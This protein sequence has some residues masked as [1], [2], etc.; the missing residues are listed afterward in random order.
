[1][2]IKLIAASLLLAQLLL[3]LGQP[4]SE[5]GL[6]LK[7]SPRALS[8]AA[9]AADFKPAKTSR[10][11]VWAEYTNEDH[12]FYRGPTLVDSTE[13][14]TAEDCAKACQDKECLFWAWCSDE[15]T[16]GC[17]ALSYA[18]IAK[19]DAKSSTLDAKT[20]LLSSD[21]KSSDRL[22]FVYLAGDSV[23]WSAG[24]LNSSAPAPSPAPSHSPAPG[25]SP[26]PSKSPQPSDSPSPS[27]DCP[28]HQAPSVDVPAG[29]NALNYATGIDL[30]GSAPKCFSVAK[31]DYEDAP[32]TYAACK[33]PEDNPSSDVKDLA[34]SLCSGAPDDKQLAFSTAVAK[35][36]QGAVDA[37]AALIYAQTQLN[38][39][40]EQE[41]SHTISPA[42]SLMKGNLLDFLLEYGTNMANASEQAGMGLCMT[43]M[44]Q[45]GNDDSTAE[46][47]VRI[48][49]GTDN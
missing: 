1:M 23:A 7:S 35:G 5:E 41:M 25:N 14:D 47:L 12:T 21:D 30:G 32:K 6:E 29:L 33:A 2:T 48:H 13:A 10:S 16:N 8:F 42:K 17:E 11:D 45:K 49:T 9:A 22:A 44:A 27:G 18:S 19:D 37:V 15:A 34:Q 4:T 26:R 43:I 40:S 36:G 31:N 28:E 39:L 20:C 24:H 46:E 3:P 38:C